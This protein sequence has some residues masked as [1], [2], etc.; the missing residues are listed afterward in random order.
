[1]KHKQ[2]NSCEGKGIEKGFGIQI[3]AIAKEL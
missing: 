1:M 3:P 2:L